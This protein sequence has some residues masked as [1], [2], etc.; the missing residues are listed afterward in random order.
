MID[1]YR[2]FCLWILYFSGMQDKQDNCWLTVQLGLVDMERLRNRRLRTRRGGEFTSGVSW[3]V[4]ELSSKLSASH[5]EI[6]SKLSSTSSHAAMMMVSRAS[7]SGLISTLITRRKIADWVNHWCFQP[8][9]WAWVVICPQ[10]SPVWWLLA[11][12]QLDPDWIS[13]LAKMPII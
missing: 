3:E 2:F 1:C 12:C 11:L 6:W 7:V 9:D 4:P 10:W 13:I 5:M 8:E